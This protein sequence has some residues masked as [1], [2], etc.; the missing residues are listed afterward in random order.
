MSIVQN[1]I[2]TVSSFF[3]FFFFVS[4]R[5][6]QVKLNLIKF[7]LKSQN[8]PTVQGLRF[9]FQY[10]FAYCSIALRRIQRNRQITT[11]TTFFYTDNSKETTHL[12]VRRH[13]LSFN[14]FLVITYTAICIRSKLSSLI[15][16]ATLLTNSSNF[17]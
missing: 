13:K 14:S 10:G 6:H 9:R 1:I 12:Y 5:A 15:F 17:S 4:Y 7:N 16:D 2:Q 11:N 3:L 8:C